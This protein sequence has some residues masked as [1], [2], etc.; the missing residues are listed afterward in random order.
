MAT[1][2]CSQPPSVCVSLVPSCPPA[3][4]APLLQAYKDSPA[5]RSGACPTS[6]IP[7][8]RMP[9]A[10]TAPPPPKM[11]ANKT[12][13]WGCFRCGRPS[14]ASIPSNDYLR[15]LLAP[16]ASVPCRPRD[17][18]VRLGSPEAA[19]RA[20]TGS[21]YCLDG[22]EARGAVIR[23]HQGATAA[24]QRR[25]HCSGAAQAPLVTSSAL[26][27]LSNCFRSCTE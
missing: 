24:W 9:P 13:R 7:R 12:R 20:P 19:L 2:G 15:R 11:F 16:G 21:L 22:Y 8:S 10:S 27:D 17:V 4:S 3:S 14:G 18:E 26:F 1:H 5:C 6:V 23:S 25:R